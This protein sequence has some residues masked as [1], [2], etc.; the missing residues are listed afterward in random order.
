MSEEIGPIQNCQTP[1]AD[2]LSWAKL[3]FQCKM[4]WDDLKDTSEPSIRFCTA[5][6]E[7]V[8]LVTNK[9][10]FEFRR[11]SQTLCLS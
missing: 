10:E 4:G 11:Y 3:S 7:N 2:A 6:H 1:P 9:E 5:C 8:H